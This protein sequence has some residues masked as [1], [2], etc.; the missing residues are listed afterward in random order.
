MVIVLKVI[1]IAGATAVLGVAALIGITAAV[2]HAEGIPW[3]DPSYPW[4]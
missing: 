1:G 2:G 3:N 4:N